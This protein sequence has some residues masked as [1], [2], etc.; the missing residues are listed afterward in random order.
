M[1][2]RRKK[3][4]NK[5]MNVWSIIAIGMVVAFVAFIAIL[6]VRKLIWDYSRSIKERITSLNVPSIARDILALK[7]L[8][9]LLWLD[10]ERVKEVLFKFAEANNL[11]QLRYYMEIGVLRKSDINMQDND[12]QTF[13]HIAVKNKNKDMFNWF[14]ENGGET[15]IHGG[16]GLKT[17]DDILDKD[18]EVQMWRAVNG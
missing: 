5:M 17:V 12:N 18:P 14:L 10:E 7:A 1:E 2:N 4:D 16:R 11:E 6:V 13:G 15:D 9:P 8:M 3:G